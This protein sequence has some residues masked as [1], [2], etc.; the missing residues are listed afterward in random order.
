MARIAFYTFGVLKATSDSEQL[1]D[2]WERLPSVFGKAELIDGFIDRSG[3]PG[4]MVDDRPMWGERVKPRFFK[5]REHADSLA[6]L[7]LWHDLESVSAFAYHGFHADALQKRRDWFIAPEWPSY[8]AWW[9]PD[10][11]IPTWMEGVSQLELLFENGPTKRAFD[12][13]RPFDSSGEPTTVD[14]EAVRVKWT[15]A[16]R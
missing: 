1:Q 5:P 8:V 11:H 4:G 9:V 14:R 7:S 2:F 15:A 6:T 16:E 12:F 10:D 13:V 3:Y